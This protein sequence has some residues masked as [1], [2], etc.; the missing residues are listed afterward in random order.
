MTLPDYLVVL[1]DVDPVAAAVAA[2]WGAPES[3]GISAEGTPIR[4][5]SDHAWSLRRAG[6]H[7]R[8]EHLERVLPAELVAAGTTLVFPSV[9]RSAQNIRCLTVHPLGNLGGTAEVGGRPRT[10]SPTDPRRMT[11]ALRRL[12]E[13]RDRVGLPASFEATHH[14]PELSLPAFFVEIGFG[15]ADGPPGEAVRLLAEVIPDLEPDP[16]DRVALA[17]GGGHYAPHFTDLALKRRWAFGHI[18]S[19]HGLEGLDAATARA[20]WTATPGAEGIVFSRA[21]DARHPVWEGLGSR[22]REQDAPAREPSST[23]G[24]RPASGT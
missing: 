10:V 2:I 1:S 20:A 24:D 8:D 21:E 13:A 15:E 23:S 7:I 4:R 6:P 3:T 22:L 5:L 12:A 18:V 16:A 14:G 17:V 11:G 9:H 19:K